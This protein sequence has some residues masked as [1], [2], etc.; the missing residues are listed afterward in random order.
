MKTQPRFYFFRM[1][2][3][4]NSTTTATA[5]AGVG[6]ARTNGDGGGLRGF[7]SSI[8]DNTQEFFES[9]RVDNS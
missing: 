5:A 3:C 2:S 8:R 7:V 1:S 4:N 6:S 9:H